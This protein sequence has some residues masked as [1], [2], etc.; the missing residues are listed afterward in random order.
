MINIKDIGR[1]YGW[2]F[3][4]IAGIV[5]G[6]WLYLQ[7]DNLIEDQVTKSAQGVYRHLDT[8]FDSVQSDIQEIRQEIK[9]GQR[10]FIGYMKDHEGRISR[11]EVELK[12]LQQPAT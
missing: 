9:E 3:V 12:K 5:G 10:Q 2:L 8:R 6:V 11:V 7:L 4:L 1:S